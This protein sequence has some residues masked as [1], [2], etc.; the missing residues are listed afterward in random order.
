M[1]ESILIENFAI[2]D[3]LEIDF[4]SGFSVITGETGAGKSIVID[5]ISQLLGDRT[6][7]SFIKEG[8]D[9]SFIEGVFVVKNK[10]YLNTLLSDYDIELDDKLIV[11]KS[12]DRSGKTIIKVN[13]RKVN[14]SVLKKILPEFI[15]IHSQFET[16]AL[17]NENNHQ[18]ILDNYIYKDIVFLLKKYQETYKHYRNVSNEYNKLI[19][20]ELSDEQLEFYQAQLNEID[21]LDLDN[22]DEDD[23]IF[24]KQEL[25]NYEKIN[26]HVK[27]FNQIM[28]SEQGLLSIFNEALNSAN[29]LSKY[30]EY[31]SF[32]NKLY[33]LYYEILGINDQIE[34]ISNL[35]YFDEDE[36]NLIQEKL[37]LFNRLKRKYGNSVEEI[38][39]SKETLM[40][41]INSFTNREE[42]LNELQLT[43]DNLHQ[44][45]N[46]LSK[47]LTAIRKKAAEEF[48]IRIK[49]HLNDLYLDKVEFKVCFEEINFN[50]YGKDKV[51]FMILTNIGSTLQPLHKIASGGE[52]SRIMLAIK[53]LT[54]E[55]SNIETIIFDEADTGVSGKVA[56][57]VGNKMLE[58]SNN[59]QVFAISHLFQVASLAN[60]HYLINK[61]ISEDNTKVTIKLLDNEES[62]LELAKMISGKEVSD[63]SIELARKIKEN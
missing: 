62:V 17:F 5:A 6:Q 34:N 26:K 19:Q 43:K 16:T 23:L 21:K 29:Q 14:T 47:D 35:S 27:E 4:N 25:S 52:L 40:D 22:F 18:K 11:S 20:E 39:N 60:N 49:K 51:T 42:I 57:S 32:S 63:E 10:E 30:P 31:E 46:S 54:I 1:L 15:D 44:E 41:K 3:H 33:D 13:Y 48:E 61:S 37:Y 45:L 50:L 36:L 38:I 55:Y 7:S 24:K 59:I 9:K 2:I 53:M 58:I 28:N 12:F 8:T 56:E